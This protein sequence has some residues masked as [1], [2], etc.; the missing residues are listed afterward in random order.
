MC[1]QHLIG[2]EPF[3]YSFADDLI[4]PN[5]FQQMIELHQELSGCILPCIEV[6]GDA[7]YKRYGI[8]GGERLRD[9]LLRM[10]RIA[11]KP[12]REAAPSNLA[13]VGGYLFT[14]DIFEYL[15]RIKD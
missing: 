15:D 3:I 4:L 12:G 14:P 11:E 9:G 5:R 8:V 7:E 1:V 10:E 6:E 13:N 2:D